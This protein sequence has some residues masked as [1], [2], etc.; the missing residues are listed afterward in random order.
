MRRK[1][2]KHLTAVGQHFGYRCWAN[3]SPHIIHPNQM[4]RQ[5]P[6]HRQH[7]PQIS[8]WQ[9]GLG[10]MQN[11]AVCSVLWRT[12]TCPLCRYEQ[13]CR[14]S[15]LRNIVNRQIY[16]GNFPMECCIVTVWDFPVAN[17]SKF[18]PLLDPLSGL[19]TNWD[20]DIN[21]GDQQVNKNRK[22]VFRLSNRF[23]IPPS[24]KTSVSVMTSSA[25]LI[26]LAP[27]PDFLQTQ[28]SCR[29]QGL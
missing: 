7:V 27:C 13:S 18:K 9:F 2:V 8:A 14:A 26:Y 4:A 20:T 5:H 28:W 22:L 12:R 17:I 21:T 11:N 6:S 23:A 16:Q 29:P 19:Q 10:H 15:A 1:H 25:G 24:T 3:H